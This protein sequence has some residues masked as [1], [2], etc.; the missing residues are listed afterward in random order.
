MFVRA[1]T[2]KGQGL[3]RDVLAVGVLLWL[4]GCATSGGPRRYEGLLEDGGGFGF[5]TDQPDDFQI[6][7][8]SA[9]LEE[10]SWHDA[11]QDL[12]TGDAHALWE[13]LGRTR[14]TLRNFGPRRSLIFLLGRVLAEDQD[15][16]YDELLQR[17]RPF[18]SLV[19]MRPDGYLASAL[20]G[21]ALQRMGRLQLRDGRLMAGDF[22]VGAFYRD[23]GGVFYAVDAL[24]QWSPTEQ[25]GE[26]GLERDWLNA[27]LDGA[28]D[29]LGEM[30]LALGQFVT[31]PIRSID[32]LKQ[33]PT[34]VAA[35]IA[36]SPDYFARY[37]ALPLQEQI[38]EA[39][40]LSTHLLAL[41]GSAAGTAAR[42]SAAGARLP[43]LSLS[44]KGALM[45]E[46]AAVPVGTTAATL[47]TG[48]GAVYVLMTAEKTPE[49]HHKPT[50]E[51]GPGE[52]KNKKFSGSER[53]RRYQEQISGR[54]ADEA[55]SIGDVEYDGFNSGVLKEA[56]GP[57]YREFFDKSG[58]PKPWYK[59]SGKFQEL[60]DQARN[61]SRAARGMPVQWHIAEREMVDILHR[62]FS[63]EGIEGI[64]LIYTPW[65]P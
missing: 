49:G 18:Q 19:V 15:V 50:A 10:N 11:G 34:A 35:L 5:S 17:T 56:K 37:S 21:S 20:T 41:Y 36:S 40:R 28:Q 65:V 30:V 32:G 4:T 51:P 8:R 27:A 46:R 9:G 31:A 64:D 61:Q 62:Y 55:Y 1:F 12:E 22:E 45:V 2:K 24:L 44:A 53:S 33:L 60:I 54:S 6:L 59:N 58:Q 43:V 23:K 57:G 14:T 7:Q 52:W 26:L 48:M 47:G 25:R 16:P 63:L 38:R 42:I 29:A 39:A 13:A 3:C